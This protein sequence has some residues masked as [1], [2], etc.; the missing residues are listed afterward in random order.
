MSRDRFDAIV[1]QAMREI[2]REFRNRLH[3]VEIVI[4]DDPSP[5]LLAEMGSEEG[6][7]L[8]GLYQGTPLTE[9]S[10]AHGNTL[11]DRIVLFR[12]PLEAACEDEDQ[13]IDEVCL[14]LIHE[15]GHY[16]GLSEAQIQQVEDDFWYGGADEAGSDEEA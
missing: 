5:E 6:E 12:R 9:R 7:T 14:T 2:P 3:N 11:P 15:A 4:E 16:F 1:R 8:F 13:L 10:W